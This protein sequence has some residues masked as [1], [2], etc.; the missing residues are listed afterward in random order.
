[1]QT[2]EDTQRAEGPSE[3]KT[4]RL[5]ITID[6][7]D[8][9]VPNTQGQGSHRRTPTNKRGTRGGKSRGGGS[10]R[11]G[12]TNPQQPRPPFQRPVRNNEPPPRAE[13]TAMPAQTVMPD[14]SAHA[15]VNL[16]GAPTAPGG[17]AQLSIR[18]HLFHHYERGP[19]PMH[20]TQGA[21]PHMQNTTN[22]A[23]HQ[24]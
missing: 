1:M 5:A 17:Y 24:F 3:A 19:C 14:A 18:V 13:T 11:G 12:F 6:R 4:P 2:E 16:D 9:P 22:Y 20:V 10:G 7:K 15:L 8:A 23:S 21:R